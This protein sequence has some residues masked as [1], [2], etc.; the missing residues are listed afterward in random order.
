MSLSLSGIDV[1]VVVKELQEQIVGSWVVNIYHIPSG[2][3]LFKLRRTQIGLQF[4]LI[5]PGKR[6]HLSNFN[7]IMPSEPSN[8]CK[9]LRSHLRDRRVNSVEQRD[10]DRI[11][12]INIGPDEGFNLVIELFG[13]GNMILVSPENKIINAMKYRKM[14]D[15]DI[16][17]GRQ[18]IHMPAVER[19]ILRNGTEGL[20]ELIPAYPKVIPLLNSWLGLGPYY[21]SYIL[22]QADIQTKKTSEL[23][24]ENLQQ[25]I[26]ESEKLKEILINHQYNPVVYL[27]KDEMEK[28]DDII[29]EDDEDSI[30]TE[31]DEQWAKLPF[32]PEDVVKI[33]PWEQMEGDNYVPNSFGDALDIFFSSQEEEEDIVGETEELTTATEKL[34]NQLDQQLL[35]QENLRKEADRFRGDA[36]A[37]YENF[38]SASEIISIVYDARRKKMEWEDI[39]ERLELGKE[40]G[41]AAAKLYD[42]IDV[43]EATLTLDLPNMG[44][45]RRVK[46]DF[47]KSLTENA[48][49]YYEKAK[50]NEK[51]SR[52][53]DIAINRT[54][55]KIKAIEEDSE[56]LQVL[57]STQDLVLKRR[58]SWYE[59]F[60]WTFAPNGMLI[61]AGTD[62]KTNEK[63]VKTYLEDGDKFLHADIQGAAATIIKTDNKDP[64]ETAMKTAA[65][66]S[67]SYSNAWKL[68][69]P[70]ADAYMVEKDQVSLSAP[71]GQFMPQGGFMIY[72]NREYISNVPLKLFIGVKIEKHWAKLLLSTNEDIDQASVIVEMVP[73]DETR[74]RIAKQIKK[75]FLKHIDEK[76]LNKIKTIE[77]GDIAF[78][79]P[80]PSRIANW[81]VKNK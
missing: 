27:D 40:K 10:L 61:I 74:G 5:E 29:L 66:I 67:V 47:R 43:K 62:A 79:I 51:K 35:H 14:K 31:F 34:T 11:I 80:G 54:R 42:S 73:G 76:D 59:K 39:I 3:F 22:K 63:L 33:L 18:F 21:S 6:I 49:G 72:G 36:D 55:E 24:S 46:V 19:D 4:L 41:I 23:N 71:S 57:T 2:I 81:I 1:R 69:R 8:F 75:G 50:K 17:P 9:T 12:I 77:L 64:S 78:M 16:H 38:Q 68:L 32:N 53:A 13:K 26:L 60:H 52:N 65:T 30:E 28:E 48:N 70:S 56:K 7:R 37:L 58:K 45:K 20:E 25:I 15:R 44:D